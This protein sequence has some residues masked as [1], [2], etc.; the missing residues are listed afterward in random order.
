M[1]T[2][3]AETTIAL[4]IEAYKQSGMSQEM[5][6]VLLAGIAADFKKGNVHKPE[7]PN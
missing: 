2:E 3:Q 4:I 5:F 1:P 7:L 6:G